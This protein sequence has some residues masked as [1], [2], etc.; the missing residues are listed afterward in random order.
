MM[1]SPPQSEAPPPFELTTPGRRP[2]PKERT[3]G[4]RIIG[5]GGGKGGIGKSLLSASLGIDLAGRGKRVVLVDADL[6]GANLHTCL[7]IEQPA[8]GVGDYLG[9]RVEG[10]AEA[11]TAT[12]VHNL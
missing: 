6:G 7:G 4:L 8:V 12:G 11:M 2:K 10:L 9:H 3:S 5:I 1:D